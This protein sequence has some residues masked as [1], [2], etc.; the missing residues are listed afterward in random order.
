[1]IRIKLLNIYLNNRNLNSDNVALYLNILLYHTNYDAL[2]NTTAW[3]MIDNRIACPFKGCRIQ[4]IWES[5][6]KPENFVTAERAELVPGAEGTLEKILNYCDEKN[7]NVLFVVCPYV[8]NEDKY[9]IY[10]S[11]GDMI[12]A[13]GYDYLNANDY[14]DQMNMDFYADYYNVDH[15][16]A[17]GAE[18]YTMFLGR[19]L[20][21]NYDLPD[22]RGTQGFE[23]WDAATDIFYEQSESMKESILDQ[24]Q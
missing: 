2:K 24:I 3:A 11:L 12:T 1:M 4:Q 17:I 5:M 18:K 20:T 16:N 14:L 7:L 10:N 22:H 21:E 19:Y 9:A 8:I 15:V 6:V 13:R 23:E